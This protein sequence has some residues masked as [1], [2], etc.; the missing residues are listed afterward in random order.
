L[1]TLID[2]DQ[3]PRLPRQLSIYFHLMTLFRLF[4]VG[5]AMG[6]RQQNTLGWLWDH[7]RIEHFGAQLTAA[8]DQLNSVVDHRTSNFQTKITS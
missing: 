3:L 8:Q 6:T 1:R 7:K 2:I 4:S 5:V